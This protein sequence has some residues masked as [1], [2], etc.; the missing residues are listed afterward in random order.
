MMKN[1]TYCVNKLEPLL[2]LRAFACLLVLA[3]HCYGALPQS[4][5]EKV[6]L[7]NDHNLSWLLYTPGQVGVWIFF[8][9]SGYLMGK[10]FYTSRYPISRLGILNFWRNR[11]LR[12]LPLYYFNLLLLFIFVTPTIL[13]PE[14]WEFI[15]RMFVLDYQEDLP[16]NPN[17]A[18]WSVSTEFQYYMFAP[19]VFVILNQFVKT[20]KRI[21]LTL[22]LCILFVLLARTVFWLELR[23]SIFLWQEAIYHPLYFNID[24]FVTGFLINPALR[25]QVKTNSIHSFY[26][27]INRYKLILLIMILGAF[28]LV[29]AYISYNTFVETRQEYQD[30]FVL[31]LPVLTGLTT[32]FVI[33][34]CEYDRVIVCAHLKNE[35]LSVSACLRNPLRIVEVFGILTYGIYIWHSPLL[36]SIE[37]VFYLPIPLNDLLLKFIVVFVLSTL[38]ASITYFTIEVPTERL[39]AFSSPVVRKRSSV[40]I[41]PDHQHHAAHNQPQPRQTREGN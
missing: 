15:Y 33:Y 20:N 28:Y 11:I 9:L 29:S 17:G 12:I 23:P 10:A 38:L 36:E 34:N 13:K 39:K 41:L 22:V 21:L 26:K 25:N 2:A 5:W 1:S 40:L 37:K 30:L 7:I 18:L 19:F 4:N 32:A 31:G 35:K 14:N 8:C 6:W 3:M 24:L 16:Y 27:S